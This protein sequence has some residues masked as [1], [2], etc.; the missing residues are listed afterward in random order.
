MDCHDCPFFLQLVVYED[1][2]N[3]E[4]CHVKHTA[5]C[6]IFQ[7]GLLLAFVEFPFLY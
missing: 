6:H 1:P 4:S 5:V 3:F 7:E 2:T